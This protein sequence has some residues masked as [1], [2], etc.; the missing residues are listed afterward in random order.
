MFGSWEDTFF[1]FFFKL[2]YSLQYILRQVCVF[3][4]KLRSEFF[5]ESQH[6]VDIQG[7]SIGVGSTS[8]PGNRYAK[9]LA[10][11]LGK[12]IG[13]TLQRKHKHPCRF[14]GLGICN[15]LPGG[16]NISPLYLI[17]P[18]LGDRLGGESD[19]ANNRDTRVDN[20][21]HGGRELLPPF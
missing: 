5:E 20:C 13:H 12:T 14:K 8:N 7:L 2:L 16:D 17:P 10:N 15:H 18:E 4:Y 9:L 1:H 11:Q 21:F 3:F 6:I 19:V